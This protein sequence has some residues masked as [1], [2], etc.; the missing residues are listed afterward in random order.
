MEQW[1]RALSC[2]EQMLTRIAACQ[3][4]RT[5][6]VRSAKGCNGKQGLGKGKPEGARA[7]KHTKRGRGSKAGGQGNMNTYI[8]VY[9]YRVHRVDACLYLIAYVTF[10]IQEPGK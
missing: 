7:I 4:A 2:L 10:F 8:C 1:L 9:I 6:N 3:R 5:H